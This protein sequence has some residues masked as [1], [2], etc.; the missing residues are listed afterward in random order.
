MKW[1]VRFAVPGRVIDGDEKI[2]REVT[3]M[4]L[5]KEKMNILVPTVHA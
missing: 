2:L 3:T 4:R 1:L 5:V